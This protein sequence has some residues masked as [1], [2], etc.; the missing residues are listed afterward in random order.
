MKKSAQIFAACV[1]VSA[2]SMGAQ[3]ASQ[4]EVKAE[5]KEVKAEKTQ[6]KVDKV[7]CYGVSSCKGKS[8]CAVTKDDVEATKAVF[9]D[10]FTK[11][12]P[13]GCHGF[14]ANKPGQLSYVSLPQDECF[15]KEG[16]LIEDKD[17]KRVVV[18][19]K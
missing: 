17:G 5:K 9:K 18:V 15:K 2:I 16:F 6:V 1:S 10:K 4:K 11:T 3:G 7:N 13:H 8:A 19:K 12:V 14:D